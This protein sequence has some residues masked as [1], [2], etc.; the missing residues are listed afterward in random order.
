MGESESEDALMTVANDV[1][2]LS[3]YFQLEEDQL[4]QHFTC[5]LF[6][7]GLDS[8]GLEVN[9]LSRYFCCEDSYNSLVESYFPTLKVIVN[10]F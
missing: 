7:A 10:I 6:L 8:A 3:K 1:F 5:E 2:L 9:K 4:W